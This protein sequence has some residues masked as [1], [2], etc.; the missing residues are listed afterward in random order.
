M[1]AVVKYV[2]PEAMLTMLLFNQMT[3]CAYLVM[4]TG[5]MIGY[6]KSSVSSFDSFL[7]FFVLYIRV[8]FMLTV[9]SLI[10]SL[11]A[12]ARYAINPPPYS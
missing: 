11:I 8:I 6:L 2:N 4:M 1:Y 12:P 9:L 3:T 7:K 5:L 10:L